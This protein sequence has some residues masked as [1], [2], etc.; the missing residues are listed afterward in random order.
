MCCSPGSYSQL[1][2]QVEDVVPLGIL[3]A[4]ST[5]VLFRRKSAQHSKLQLKTVF[6]LS[7]MKKKLSAVSP[8]EVL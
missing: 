6:S 7:K 2:R 1:G 3:E 5:G 8:S 4:K